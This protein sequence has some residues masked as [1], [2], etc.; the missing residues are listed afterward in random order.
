MSKDTKATIKVAAVQ[1]SPIFL[2]KCATTE[3]VCALIRRAGSQNAQIIGFPETFIPGYPGWVEVLPLHT[4]QAASLFLKLFNESVEVPGPETTAIGAACKEASMYAV[5]GVNERRAGTTGT[6]FNTNLFFGP[7]GSILHKHQKYVPTVGE[8]LVHAPGQTGSRASV[9]TE[10]GVL[11]SLIC[12][13]NGNPLAQYAIGLDYPVIHVASWPGHFGE[14]MTVNG[15]INVFGPAVASSVGCFV[16]HA[17]GVVGDDA[18]EVYGADENSRRFLKE[19]QKQARACV[20]G[21][22]G[23]I[24]AK[25]SEGDELVF[26]DV[27]VDDLVKAKYGLVSSVDNP[28]KYCNLLII[29]VRTMLGIIIDRKYSLICLRNILLNILQGRCLRDSAP[30]S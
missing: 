19:Q 9:M 3:K 30:T 16:V 29:C 1:A 24:L 12:G 4:D 22:G 27:C 8:R 11:S 17:V 18:I 2:D 5:V 15:A 14:G 7:D 26:A 6:L 20:M 28:F 10:F 23:R 13:E 21:P 25:G